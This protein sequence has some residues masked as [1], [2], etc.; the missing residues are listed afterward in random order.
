MNYKKISDYYQ[1]CFSQHG[2]T[3]EGFAWQNLDTMILR[4]KVMSELIREDK[5]ATLLDLG[6]GSGRF[7]E[8]LNQKTSHIKYTGADIN[9]EAIDFCKSKY[10]S[11]DF[12]QIDVLCNGNAL[13]GYDY[14]VM[15]G[16]FTVKDS[17][18][19][20]QMFKFLQKMISITYSKVNIGLAF[21]VM[22]KHVDWERDDLFHLPYDDLAAF[23]CKN[24]SR[25]FVIRND[26]GLYEYT[27][28]LY[29]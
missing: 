29:K 18:S 16:I 26:Y 15:N 8:Y 12:F 1:R 14:I 23:L 19:F 10:P 22:S 6:C 27:T 5:P 21:N 25:D 2:D 9:K 28:Y 17:L 11:E 3:P 13:P 20:D 7:L 24:L 4:Y